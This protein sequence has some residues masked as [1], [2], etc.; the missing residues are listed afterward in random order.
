[1]GPKRRSK[2]SEQSSDSRVP[3]LK[4]RRGVLYF[5]RP[6]WKDMMMTS[7]VEAARAPGFISGASATKQAEVASS[8]C[9]SRCPCPLL[10]HPPLARCKH[11]AHGEVGSARGPVDVLCSFSS[12]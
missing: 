5:P 7:D 1:M 9:P 3:S 4:L 12:V 11:M 8:Q 6:I 2:V 10:A